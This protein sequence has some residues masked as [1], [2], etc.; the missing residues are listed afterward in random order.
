MLETCGSAGKGERKALHRAAGRSHDHSLCTW[1]SGGSINPDCARC[2]RPVLRLTAVGVP[3][4]RR[5]SFEEEFRH[6][7]R[8][9]ARSGRTLEIN[10]ETPLCPE[11]V[12]S[13]R[14][15]GG[16]AVTFGSDAHEP[17]TLAS[18]FRDAAAMAQAC[19]FRPGQGH[20]IPGPGP[21]GSFI[22]TSAAIGFT[23]MMRHH[24]AL[25]IKAQWCRGMSSDLR[26]HHGLRV[27]VACGLAAKGGGEVAGG[28]SREPA[29]EIAQRPG[30]GRL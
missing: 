15:E 9:L 8:V 12:R 5:S 2:L 14:D 27:L 24:R 29:N 19:S 3:E 4:D 28:S 20:V 18:Q 30:D 22:R 13:W 26:S 16:T 10:T 1:L 23:A 25:P 11:I 6:A 7:L 17:D 21:R